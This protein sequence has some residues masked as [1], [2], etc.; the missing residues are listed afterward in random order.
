MN[1]G[2]GRNING[3]GINPFST[4]LDFQSLSVVQSPVVNSNQFKGSNY[5]SYFGS[6]NYSFD[7]KYILTGVI[8]RDGS[9][10]FGEN[11]GYGTFPAASVGWNVSSEPFMQNQN[12]ISNLQFRAGWGQMGSDSNVSPNNQFSLFASDRGNTWYPIDGQNSG[13]NEGFAA[14]RIGNTNAQW[15]TSETTNIGFDLAF[16][17][18]KLEFIFDWWKKDT[19]DLLY[20]VPL[21]GTT[22]NYAAAPSVNIG[23]M[24]NSGVDF[25]LLEEEILQK[26]LHSK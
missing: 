19:K 13:A 14:S 9:S 1:D 18:D 23:G 21:P 7:E 10:R 25:R 16:W 6:L 2:R 8:R 12:F 5:F 17:N 15:E 22:G 26:T 3:S 20:Q 24:S 4:D 11:T